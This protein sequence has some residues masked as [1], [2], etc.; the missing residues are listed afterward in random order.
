MMKIYDQSV[1]INQNPNWSYILDQRYRILLIG[2][3]GSGKFNVL[4]NIIKHERPDIDKIY[5]Y[6]KDQSIDCLLMKEKK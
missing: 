6:A 1:K 2:G 4:L 3:S 5:L